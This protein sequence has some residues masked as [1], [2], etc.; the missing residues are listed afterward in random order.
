MV[1]RDKSDTRGSVGD[2]DAPYGY[3]IYPQAGELDHGGLDLWS[4]IRFLRRRKA[5]IIAVTAIGTAM[6][7]MIGHSKIPFYSAEAHLMLE[8]DSRV[9]DLGSSVGGLSTDYA[10]METE[11]N[12]LTSRGFLNELAEKL[13]ARQIEAAPETMLAAS[14][15]PRDLTF[16]EKLEERVA[17]VLPGNWLVTS[18]EATEPVRMTPEQARRRMRD[19]YAGAI[20]GG[21]RVEQVGNSY[22]ISI[23]Y[24]SPK[25]GETARVANGVA[26][27]YVEDQ[28]R[29][30]RSVTGRATEFLEARL[31]ELEQ[32]VRTAEEAIADYLESSE[33]L[34]LR[35]G[36]VNT[37]QMIELTNMQVDSRAFRKERE[38]RLRFIRDLQS[39]GESLE[40]LTEVLQSPYIV[41]LWQEESN[42]RRQEAELRG[43]YGDKHPAIQNVLGEQEKVRERVDIEITRIIANLENEL[44]VLR[45]R[46]RSIQT[47]IDAL[48]AETGDAGKREIELRRLEREAVASRQ[49]YENF[50]QRYKETREQQEIV[51]PNARVI[52]PAVEPSGPSSRSP[53]AYVRSAFLLS[54]LVGVFLA[55]IRERLDNGVRSGKEIE[56]ALGVPCLGLVPHLTSRQRNGK[57]LHEYLVEKPLSTYTETI[58]SLYTALRLS[59]VDTPPKVIQVS[60]SV[61][62]EGKTTLAASL[63]AALSL[64]GRKVVLMDCDMRHPSVRREIELGGRGC[65]VSYLTGDCD[66][67]EALKREEIGQFD[68]ID[69]RRTPPNPS[70]LLGSKRMADLLAKLRATYDYV[71]IDGPPVLGVSDSKVIMEQADTVL[72][73][74]RWEKTT[75][76]TA[77]DAVKEMRACG[78]DIVGSVITQVNIARHAQYG[79]G[80]I[81]GYYNKYKKY[82]A[83]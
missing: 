28:L 16:M 29:R 63:A 39:R 22:V 75:M 7:A 2:T 62:A 66:F 8:K 78:A 53:D 64:D 48:V 46:E 38:A 11:I 83:N 68:V 26:N 13:Y 40:S 33:L 72:Y 14:T 30:K 4:I 55:F 51:E 15:T 23:R 6:G 71:I 69:V 54:A 42:L 57:K 37:Q 67:D 61:P 79:Y 25:A 32:E 12:L 50:L 44:S 36:D 73:V 31:V 24:T 3:G 18:T 1:T 77:S 80:G 52:A 82:Y 56:K 10:A 5:I 60:S 9:I 59:N 20:M 41:S 19:A 65:L 74:V 34:E 43:V 49:L 35:S 81:D 70:R 17:E 27:L 76:D 45:E 47:D 21:L 58:R